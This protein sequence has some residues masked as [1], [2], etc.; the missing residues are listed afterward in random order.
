MTIPLPVSPPDPTR[1]S[2]DTTLGM[3][4]AA[5]V[6]TEPGGRVT[7]PAPAFGLPSVT[8][9]GAGTPSTLSALCTMEPPIVPPSNA[10]TAA[11]RAS[12]PHPGRVSRQLVEGPYGDG[13]Y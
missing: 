12:A 2:I 11:T 8:L 4:F 5:T 13:P 9:R 3:I 1:T 7:T 10:A 6:A